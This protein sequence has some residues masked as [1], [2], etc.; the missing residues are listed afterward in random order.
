MWSARSLKPDCVQVLQDTPPGPGDRHHII[1]TVAKH[2][3]A[4]AN[5]SYKFR[6]S[7]ALKALRREA[8]GIPPGAEAKAAWKGVCKQLQKE[9]RA[10]KQEL[11]LKAGSSDWNALRSP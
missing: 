3:T 2:I 10:W 11:I 8:R 6:E 4:P 9:R 7:T 1:A 5:R